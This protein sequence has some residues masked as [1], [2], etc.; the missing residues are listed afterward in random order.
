MGKDQV[1]TVESCDHVNLLVEDLVACIKKVKSGNQP[2]EDWP[3]RSLLV[4]MVMST[5]FESANKNGAP[6]EL[7][8][9][10]GY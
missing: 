7:G 5:I 3:K 4:H 8:T 9:T 6:I 2:D 1:I 10:S